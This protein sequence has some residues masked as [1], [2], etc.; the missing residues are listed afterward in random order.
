MLLREIAELRGVG[1][2]SPLLPFNRT[3]PLSKPTFWK[4]LRDYG[5]RHR[6]VCDQAFA[7]FSERGGYPIAHARADRTWEEIADYLNETIIRCVIQ[8]DL[9]LGEYGRKR[10]QNLL[11]ELFRLA[12]RYAVTGV[13]AIYLC[14][15]VACSFRCER[16]MATCVGILATPQQYLAH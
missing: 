1:T 11:E 8:H 7:A 10:D 15:Q 13:R 3:E 5:S 16:R 4:E 9:R 2:L 6:Q 14:A 12:C